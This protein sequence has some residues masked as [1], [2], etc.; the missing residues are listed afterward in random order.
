MT[1]SV[2]PSTRACVSRSVTGQARHA[3]SGPCSR[4]GRTRGVRDL[5]EPL[6]RV[7]PPVEHEVLD[8]LAQLRL[9]LVGD[10]QR[11]RVHDAHP[12]PAADRVVQEDGVDRLA[13]GLL[14]R[15]ENETLLIPPLTS[16][17]GNRRRSSPTVSMNAT[18]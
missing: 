6:G 4:S 1:Y 10:R 15:N 12:Q 7:G 9:D 14:P 8:P 2:I 11:A 16:E 17:S 13:H 3:R 18:P 5:Q